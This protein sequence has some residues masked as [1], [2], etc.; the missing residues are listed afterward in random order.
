MTQDTEQQVVQFM[1]RDA[2]EGRFEHT[3][4]EIA[5]RTSVSYSDVRTA[6]AVLVE[7]GVIGS[8]DRTRKSIPYYYLAELLTLVRKTWGKS[9]EG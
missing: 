1:Q 6:L 8:R 4:G 3:I 7:R 2:V 9:T 5:E